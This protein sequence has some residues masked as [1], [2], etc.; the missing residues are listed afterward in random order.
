MP[1]SGLLPRPWGILEKTSPDFAYSEK[2]G[3]MAGNGL[4]GSLIVGVTG[5]PPVEICPGKNR[6]IFA[7][8]GRLG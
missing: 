7:P 4:L 8:K 1:Q 6:Y 5:A 3:I 2:S